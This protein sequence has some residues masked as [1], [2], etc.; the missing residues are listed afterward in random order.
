MDE[1]VDE[2]HRRAAARLREV[3]AI[4]ERQRDLVLLGAYRKGADHGDRRRAGA[5]ARGRGFLAAEARRARLVRRQRAARSSRSFAMKK[6]I[7]FA[8]AVVVG[9][10]VARGRA[11]SPVLSAMQAE[12]SRAM[13]RMRLKGYEAPYFIAY[14]VRDYQSRARR[15]PLRR[16]RR[17]A[18]EHTTAR[19]RPRCASA[20]TSSTTPSSDRELQFDLGDADAWDPPTEAPLDDDPEALR[21]T[22]WLLT[23]AQVQEGAGRLRQ[24]ARQARDDDQRGRDRCPASRASRRRAT[25]TRPR[26]SCG[27]SSRCRRARPRRRRCSSS[28]PIC[29]RARSRCRAT[30]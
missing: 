25:S 30:A 23:D 11:V 13:A 18:H 29:S 7:P 2:E 10:A 28:I 15:Q 6:L 1:L 5:P 8:F 24:E 9:R 4:Y 14:A 22:L 16:A 26:R 17:Q 12:L 21:G 27:T 3:L 19:R 20:T